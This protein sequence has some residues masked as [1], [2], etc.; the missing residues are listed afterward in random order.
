[1]GTVS[2]WDHVHMDTSFLTLK[3]VHLNLKSK[4]HIQYI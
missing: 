2:F 3:I 4:E 1:M